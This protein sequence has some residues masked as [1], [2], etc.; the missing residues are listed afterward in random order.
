MPKVSVV[1]PVYNRASHV[2]YAIQSILDQT[3]DDWELLLINDAST[4]GTHEV[5]QG[6]AHHDPRIRVINLDTNQGVA[7]ARNAGQELAC[8]EYIAVLD[9]DDVAHPTRLAKQVEYLNHHHQVV[10]V[11]SGTQYVGSQT[12]VHYPPATNHAAQIQLLKGNCYVHSSLM[13][14]HDTLKKHAICYYSDYDTAEDYRLITQMAQVGQLAMVPDILVTYLTHDN[15]LSVSHSEIQSAHGHRTRLAYWHAAF[16]TLSIDFEPLMALF[17]P[18]PSPISMKVAT[19][20]IRLCVMS[21]AVSGRF[22]GRLFWDLSVEMM[23]TVVNQNGCVWHPL[24]W[25]RWQV[26][27]YAAYK[28]WHLGL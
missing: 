25:W 3:V 2:G 7:R 20:N 5:I 17:L 21:N 27:P 26:A 19:Q 13:L 4:D 8:G 12:H 15:Q 16:P 22:D 24:S 1:M 23:R 18:C 11:G 9:S 6:Y 14:R 28:Q 10:L